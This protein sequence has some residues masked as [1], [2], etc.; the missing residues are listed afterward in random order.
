MKINSLPLHTYIVVATTKYSKEFTYILFVISFM[1]TYP[2]TVHAA[3]PLVSF[4]GKMKAMFVR[5]EEVEEDSVATTQTMALFRPTVVDGSSTN[6]AE[7]SQSNKES[8]QAVSGTLRLSTEDIDFPTTDEISVYEVKKGDTLTDVA[9]LFGVSVNT[10]MWANDLKSKTISQGDTLVILPVTGIK[11]TV[12]K[13]D[14]VTSLAR[15]Y[16][17]DADD[18]AKYNG[19]LVDATLTVGGVV[20]VPDGEIEVV[21]PVKPKTKAKTLTSAVSG[22]FTRPVV[23]GKK[24]QGIHGH[25]AIDIAATPGTPVIAAAAGRAIVSKMGGYNGGYG[26]MIIISHANGIQTV[27]AHLQDVYIVQGQNVTQGQVIGEVGNSGRS[28]G[29]HLHFEI[30]GAKNPF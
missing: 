9:R 28:T 15:K 12:K 30:R 11:H 8:L 13:G 14:S 19:L 2:L 3:N 29:P 16:K 18:I 5:E 1:M 22:F 4:G 20:L 21:Q 10:I 6:S 26:N 7:P 23:G 24:T 27:Y 25:N 17:A